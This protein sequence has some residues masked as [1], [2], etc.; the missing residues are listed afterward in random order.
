[1]LGVLMHA[2]D[3]DSNQG[4]SDSQLVNE[5][6][7]QIVAGRETTVARFEQTAIPAGMTLCW[8]NIADATVPVLVVV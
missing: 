8:G 4:M 5:I 7:T 1:M 3:K 6:L 2:S